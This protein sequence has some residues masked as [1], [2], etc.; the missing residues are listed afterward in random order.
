M[1]MGIA[2]STEQGQGQAERD[3]EGADTGRER[4]GGGRSFRVHLIS[5]LKVSP[6]G[7]PLVSVALNVG[8]DGT[9]Y[10]F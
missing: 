4:E 7:T 9:E 2:R 5:H 6:K 1:C 8:Q 10:S 3:R